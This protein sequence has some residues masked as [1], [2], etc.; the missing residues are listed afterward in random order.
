M[1][2]TTL[3][4][5]SFETIRVR[6]QEPV[7]AETLTAAARIVAEV[8][9]DGEP[10]LRALVA[11]LDGRAEDAPL[12]LG[13]EAMQA[14]HARLDERTRGVLERTAGRIRAFAEEQK[15]STTDL[16]VHA[17]GGAMGHRV[18]PVGRAGCYAPGGRYPYPSTVLMTAIPPRVAGVAEVWLATPAPTDVMLG[19]AFAAGVDRV[20]VAGGAHAVAAL[21]YG[22]DGLV[23]AC[24]ALVGPG[25]RWVTAAKQLVAGLVRIDGLAGPSELVVLA[26]E[27]ADPDLVAAD[28]IA[29][30]EHD[31]DAYVA[32]VTTAP[33]IVEPVREALEARLVDLTTAEVA[34]AS[35]ARS[36]TIVVD[37]L[38]EA[39]AACDALAPEHLQVVVR[40]PD[41]VAPRLSRYGALFVGDGAAEVF[42]DY[43]AGP[44]HTLPTGGTARAFS[45]LS[46]ATFLRTPT[47][48]RADEAVLDADVIDDAVAL[49][50]LE[51]LAGHAAAARARR[52]AL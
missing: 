10:A 34:R 6:R 15:R 52:R 35:L 21:A 48:L 50:E 39:V 3:R 5:V 20:L 4:I 28:L 29:Q 25:N 19:A 46:V 47:F 12:V 1:S 23:P 32:L 40:D 17:A 24:D 51:G 41:V 36:E 13:P 38:D 16:V 14:A 45:G 33:A 7:D 18:L 37:S 43:G 9:A 11:R 2:G 26:D 8:R 30:A 31:P 44:N 27:T 49:A 42:G 22:V